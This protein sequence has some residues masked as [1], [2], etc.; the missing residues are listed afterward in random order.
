MAALRTPLVDDGTNAAGVRAEINFLVLRKIDCALEVADLGDVEYFAA[1]RAPDL[2][3]RL[4]VD[5]CA[6]VV[7]ELFEIR[8]ELHT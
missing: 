1:E 7:A 2:S 5:E 6:A 4:Y 3:L 8:V